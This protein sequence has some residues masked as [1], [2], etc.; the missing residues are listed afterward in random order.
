[1]RNNSYKWIELDNAGKIFPGQ[2]MKRWSN[3]F[4]LSVHF[5]EK[6]APEILKLAL[7]D[8]LQRFPSFK[9][10][11]RKGFFWKKMKWSVP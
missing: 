5:K 4:R 10:K 11:M 6:I 1:M 9:V 3:V 2:N 8:T 7:E